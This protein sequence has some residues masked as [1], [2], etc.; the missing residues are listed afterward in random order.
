P[1]VRGAMPLP[2][3]DQVHVIL[4]A[5]R[6]AD[7]M[8]RRTHFHRRPDAKRAGPEARPDRVAPT[9]PGPSWPYWMAEPTFENF[10]LAFWPRNVMAAMQTTAIRATRRAYSTRLAPRSVPPKRARR[11][12]AHCCC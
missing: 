4:S 2:V 8:G 5:R 12:G 11:Y 6:R 9:A 10:E 7:F 1:H 3:A